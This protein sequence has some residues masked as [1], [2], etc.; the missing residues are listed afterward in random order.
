MQLHTPGRSP[1][2]FMPNSMDHSPLRGIFLNQV[3]LN[4]VAPRTACYALEG[5]HT[6]AQMTIELLYTCHILCD[7]VDQY[8]LLCTT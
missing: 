5:I 7:T 1:L 4:N 6:Q 8:G 3:L 2:L